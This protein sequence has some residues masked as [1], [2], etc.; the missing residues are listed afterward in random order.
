MEMSVRQIG[1]PVP[2]ATTLSTQVAQ[3]R[4]EHVRVTP[5][6]TNGTPFRCHTSTAAVDCVCRW[7]KRR[8]TVCCTRRRGRCDVVACSSS[9]SSHS[10]L[11]DA[12]L[13]GSSAPVHARSD[14]VT[15]GAQ[16]LHA[17]VRL[18]VET[19][20]ARLDERRPFLHCSLQSNSWSEQAVQIL[21]PA[22]SCF[23]MSCN[24]M[25]CIFMCCNLVLQFHVLH[26]HP[27]E[28]DGPSF[29]S[30]AFSVDPT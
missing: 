30:P 28:F 29:S 20:H 22:L 24:F 9:S 12:S 11:D 5:Q 14:A 21:H 25:S 27:R 16:Q 15:D 10:S 13:S 8:R 23:F 18:G 19:S 26:F 1:Q 17:R 7:R 4:N 6:R 3:I 2:I